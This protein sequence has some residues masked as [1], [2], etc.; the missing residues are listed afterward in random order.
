MWYIFEVWKCYVH[1]IFTEFICYDDACHLK[2]FARNPVRA[3]LTSEAEKLATTH[4][5]VDKMHM[6]G[7][8]DV[9]CKEN[10]NADKFEALNKV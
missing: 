2:K 6:K 10:C 9:W 8:T 7:H 4:M 5:V 3:K 1:N